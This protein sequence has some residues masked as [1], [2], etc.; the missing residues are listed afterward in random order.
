MKVMIFAAALPFALASCAPQAEQAATVAVTACQRTDVQDVVGKEVRNMMLKAVSDRGYMVALLGLDAALAKSLEEAHV[1]F[2]DVGVYT[3]AG[4]ESPFKQIICAGSLQIDASTTR[5]G[6][7]IVTMPHLRW[8]VNFSQPAEEPATAAFT[9]AVD[10]ASL[11]DGL[12]VNGKPPANTEQK[13]DE[14]AV[15]EASAEKSAVDAAAAADA[16]AEQA[17]AA[18]AE[19]EAAGAEAAAASDS[20]KPQPRRQ[21]TDDDLYAPHNN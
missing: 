8:T 17:R 16:A 1:T 20:T 7:D 2:T 21:P 11:R 15:P 14:A 6:Q 10:P 19:A 4:V 13:A 5:A 12:L 3:G 18:Q 9:V